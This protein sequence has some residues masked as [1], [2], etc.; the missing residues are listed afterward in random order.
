[1]VILLPTFYQNFF[2][3]VLWSHFN[4][5]PLHI[6]PILLVFFGIHTGATWTII[7]GPSSTTP[8]SLHPHRKSF[9]Q[10][11]AQA[12]VAA[13][14]AS[15]QCCAS[16]PFGIS[17]PTYWMRQH[18]LT[19]S[20][21]WGGGRGASFYSLL[22]SYSFS[23]F[24]GAHSVQCPD[25]TGQWLHPEGQAVTGDNEQD[26]CGLQGQHWDF[27]EFSIKPEA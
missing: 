17:N 6:P 7:I 13:G 18:K 1:M 11:W 26:T 2:L 5:A 22:L 10:A 19:E 4:A 27:N 16:G 15:S 24:G 20:D 9:P 12:A 3:L 21:V 23:D 14:E 25:S 8:P